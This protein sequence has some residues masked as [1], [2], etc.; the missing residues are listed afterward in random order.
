MAT[1]RQQTHT[2]ILVL[3]GLVSRN[4]KPQAHC[5][6]LYIFVCI[7]A[8][9]L[10]VQHPNLTWTQD[11]KTQAQD[12]RLRLKTQD[13]RLRLDSAERVELTCQR[14]GYRPYWRGRQSQAGQW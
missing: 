11:L 2:N 9:S 3:E 6:C 14:C 5:I 8:G 13:S 1:T 7:C 4:P 12:S 10:R